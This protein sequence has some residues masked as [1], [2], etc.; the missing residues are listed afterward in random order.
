MDQ[1]KVNV[2][3]A[4]PLRQD[5]QQEMGVTAVSTVKDLISADKPVS[6]L[7]Q[8]VVIAGQFECHADLLVLDP[9]LGT[10]GLVRAVTAQET[11]KETDTLI[12]RHVEHAALIRHLVLTHHARKGDGAENN[13]GERSLPLTVELVL[14]IP[15]K[16]PDDLRSR[17][18]GVLVK[19]A[20]QDS[21]LHGI[22]VN[23][24][25][26]SSDDAEVRKRELRRAFCWLLTATCRWFESQ[27]FGA[28]EEKPLS[29]MALTDWRLAGRREIMLSPHQAS[30]KESPAW[31]YLIHG[32][33]G[34]GKSSLV[35]A[36]EYAMLG[37]IERLRTSGH[38]IKDV[39]EHRPLGSTASKGAAKIEIFR[40]GDV[41]PQVLK[42]R[43]KDGNTY[44]AP[45]LTAGSFRLDQKAMDRLTHDNDVERAK[46]F[47]RAFFAE[48]IDT[49]KR[50]AEAKRVV[51][52]SIKTP[53]KN[54]AQ[55]LERT[56]GIKKDEWPEAGKTVERLAW[57][58]A[59]TMDFRNGQAA[60]CL[61]FP[62]DLMDRLP[63]LAPDPVAAKVALDGVVGSESVPGYEAVKR[64]K[65]L[66]T[67]LRD[68]AGQAKRHGRTVDTAIKAL[69]KPNGVGQWQAKGVA[70]PADP[71]E[72]LRSWTRAL[73]MASLLRRQK[74]LRDALKSARASG[75]EPDEEDRDRGL[76]R[77]LAPALEATDSLDAEINEQSERWEHHKVTTFQVLQAVVGRDG[78]DLAVADDHPQEVASLSPKEQKALDDVTPWIVTGDIGKGMPL[79]EAV[80]QALQKGIVTTCGT[81]EIGTEAW[82]KPLVEKLNAL[83]EALTRLEALDGTIAAGRLEA[84]TVAPPEGPLEAFDG[85]T[86]AGRLEALR[87]MRSAL[88]DLMVAEKKLNES[89]LIRIFP[90]PDGK[91]PSEPGL[92]DALNEL[93]VVFTPARWAYGDVELVRH[94][95]P[96]GEERLA[97]RH[98]GIDDA[99]FFL[100]TAELNVFTV[101][102]FLICAPRQNNP[103]WTLLFDD[104]LQNMD[105]QTVSVLARGLGK[106]VTLLP[107]PWRLIMLFHGKEDLDRFHHELP[108]DVFRLPWLRPSGTGDTPNQSP[109]PQKPVPPFATTHTRQKAEGLITS[110]P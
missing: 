88:G 60:D 74:E 77:L 31:I 80:E 61:P 25:N 12:R 76:F 47:V 42:T 84:H 9:K 45:N 52:E 102:L 63:P 34:A 53:D 38:E 28:A 54:M 86:A 46:F 37:S 32:S 105:E 20:E 22:G 87:W 19:I 57:A 106:V 95:K 82:A 100:N 36:L 68:L 4:V 110:R 81:V 8:T 72:A 98:G 93:M 39:V 2:P 23:I 103:L 73:A 108:A 17:I 44:F 107:G 90:S 5:L 41:K 16:A 33:N 75:W 91:P 65:A 79:G 26:Y 71:V 62:A 92:R 99:Q 30:D 94:R 58:E 64:L 48:D 59:D 109:R 97:L 13:K 85:T 83:R 7:D 104:P 69:T 6:L 14:M 70:P 43:S 96:N 56:A 27:S 35:E 51:M 66:D 55:F 50:Y 89:F 10:L 101:A 11:E 49:A 78:A 3:V 1:T 21:Y 18:G 24:L 40:D 67:V 29:G 15:P